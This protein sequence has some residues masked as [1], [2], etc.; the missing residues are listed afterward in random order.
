M[1]TNFYSNLLDLDKKVVSELYCLTPIGNRTSQVE[2]L[3]S[4]ISRLAEEH[5][6]SVGMLMNKLIF[7]LINNEYL[8]KSSQYGGNRF[9]DGARSLN[10]YCKNSIAFSK[11]VQSLTL[12]RDL[13]DLTLIRLKNIVSLRHLLKQNLSWCPQCLNEF[14]INTKVH[15]PLAW[16]FQAFQVCLFHE[17][18]LINECPH[19][20]SVIPIL[21]RKSLNGHCPYC[22][23]WIGY[24]TGDNK[25]KYNTRHKSINSNIE[26]LLTLDTRNIQKISYS[27]ER[28]VQRVSQGNITEFARLTNIPKVTMWDWIRGEKLPDL[29]RL[30]TICFQLNVSIKEL[31]L[32]PQNSDFEK[33]SCDSY[34][35]I[36]MPQKSSRRIINIQLLRAELI[37]Y[38]KLEIP[39]SLTQVSKEIGYD[40]KVLYKHF[41]KECERIVERFYKY[42][43]YRVNLRRIELSQQVKQAIYKLKSEDIYP[44]RRKVEEFLGKPGLLREQSIKLLWKAEVHKQGVNIE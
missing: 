23:K 6:V 42:Q 40:R 25:K 27:L 22:N 13:M 18:E 37:K 4:Y 36:S 16:H 8:L 1:D 29:N 24:V 44:S 38:L 35:L 3:T 21:T 15:Y 12:R 19:C 10:G 7:P 31:L 17:T 5:N 34:R 11:T 9:Y 30:L 41:P 43:E 14:K 2:S 32:E 20:N 33:K 39:I 28:L 26:Q